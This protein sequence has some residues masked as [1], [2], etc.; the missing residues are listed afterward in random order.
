MNPCM[1]SQ[2][3]IVVNTA[4][5]YIRT[6]INVCLALY[7][8]RLILAAL[9]QTDYGI[10]SL[11]AGVVAMLSFMTGALV[12][13][14]QR[15]LSFYHG[16][17]D[18]AQIYSIFGNSLLLHLLMGGGLF[19]LLVVVAH[20]VIYSALNIEPARENAAMA[21]YLSAVVML[22]LTFLT[23]PFRALFIARE[24]IVYISVVDVLD[25]ILKL[26]IAIFLTYIT[27]IDKLVIYSLL[28]I[29]ISL[30][31]LL[32]FAV[33]A[34][35]KFDECHLPRLREW[36]RQHI[37]NLSGFA[38]WTIYQTGCIMARTQGLAII[39]N[40]IFGS[41]I[42]AAYGIAQQVCGAV[43][44]V[45]QSVLNAMT[46]QLIK[47]EGAGQRDKMLTLAASASKY[48]TLLMAMVVIP[49]VAE[50]PTI[51]TLWLQQVPE[52]AVMFCRLVLIAAVC[53]QL[54]I[55]LGVA[56][57][58][59]GQIRNYSLVVNSIKVL[60]LPA[61]WLCLHMGLPV[62]TVMWC[63]VAFELLCAMVRLPF[64][65]ITGGLHIG[66][67]LLHVFVRSLCPIG[68]MTLV[69][70]AMVRYVDMP[71]RFVVTLALSSLAGLAAI[72]LTAL[73][74]SEKEIL[75]QTLIWKTNRG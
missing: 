23:A 66:R 17:Q 18:K 53:D 54:T 16:K 27:S 60:T 67:F 11:V 40:R 41:A 21:V 64:L 63:Y 69:S 44:F 42:N 15:Y 47:A 56:N 7:S 4:A 34:L 57:Q 32:A 71:W 50:M 75:K 62:R 65:K 61:A 22:L 35:K 1:T 10:Y 13:T 38:G 45:A 29:S 36:N 3:R 2:Q 6:L 20:P 33:F 59:I 9:G 31:N 19:V 37:R 28:L 8:T 73:T 48:A 68:V 74:H 49:L 72:W 58:A 39:L 5:Q 24:N 52:H 51:L 25:G 43:F 30:F 26:L 55:G 46:P 70:I 12:S 14:T